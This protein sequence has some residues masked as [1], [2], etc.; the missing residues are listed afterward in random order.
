L[1]K[2]NKNLTERENKK[3]NKLT[4]PRKDLGQYIKITTEDYLKDGVQAIDE[5]DFT[6]D[7]DEEIDDGVGESKSS[8]LLL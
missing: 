3:G 5:T 1:N 6:T 4:E 7:E 2:Q 8:N